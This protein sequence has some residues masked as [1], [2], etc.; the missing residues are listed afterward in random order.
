VA[1]F[2]IRIINYVTHLY[3]FDLLCMSSG[4]RSII[5]LSDHCDSS[6]F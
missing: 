5:L 3:N 2:A 6:V 1:L 4:R